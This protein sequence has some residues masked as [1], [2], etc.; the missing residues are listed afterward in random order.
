M[1]GTRSGAGPGVTDRTVRRPVVALLV[2]LALLV[3]APACDA[4]AVDGHDTAA[5]APTWEDG[6]DRLDPARWTPGPPHVLGR[7]RIDPA[8]VRV[9][10]GRLALTLPAGTTDGA[11][12][13]TVAA[14]P[15]GTVTVRM[16]AADAPDS[17]TGFF[18]YAPPDFAHEIDIEL[19]DDPAGVVKLTTYDGGRM[20]HTLDVDL[21]FD[22]TA[23]FHDYAI[24]RSAGTVAFR[25]DGRLLVT[26]T[27]G[28]PTVPL[29]LYLNAWF[30]QWLGG[31]P[32]AGDRATVVDGVG[33]RPAEPS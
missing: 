26:W 19:F 28:V 22:P 20:T 23:A 10:D 15:D 12:V 3:P 32:P 33:F 18:F 6:F 27:D 30:P 17:I 11:E 14:L 24:T 4:R 31:R 1:T 9:A 16:R 13:S 21:P 7:S 2:L 5:G 25:V 8:N 29:N